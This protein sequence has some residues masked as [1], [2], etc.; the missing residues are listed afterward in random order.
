[1][2]CSIDLHIHTCASDGSDSPA[3]VLENIRR[4]GIHTFAITDHDTISGSA[5]MERLDLS[6]L[7]FLRGIEFSCVSPKGKCH[8]LGY[9]FDPAAPAFQAAL[10]E[11]R[12]L[13]L[14]KMQRR[15]RFLAERFG[16]VLTQS[17]EDWLSAQKSPGKPHFGQILVRRGIAP[18]LTSAIQEY[19]NPC[20]GGRDRIDADTAVSA[21]LA[22]GGTP[23]WAHPLGGE[24]EKRLSEDSFRAQLEYLT[25]CGINGLECFYSRY[26]EDEIRFLLKE[27]RARRLLV[28]G[29]SDYHGKNKKN[30]SLGKLNAGNR[31][32]D[33][34]LITIH[35]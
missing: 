24:G 28:S 8:I 11:G 18:D 9:G 12:Q 21:I 3:E 27:A 20:K 22:A 30:I 13:R 17:E 15:I 31:P 34:N 19:I 10:E 29:G 32:I 1:M 4:A 14:D 16:I 25:G 33:E 7:T 23:V 35:R 6:G 5:E 26:E 2:T